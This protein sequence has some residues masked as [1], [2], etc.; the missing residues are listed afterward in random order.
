MRLIHCA[1]PCAELVDAEA[2]AQLSRTPTHETVVLVPRE[3]L[4][5]YARSAQV[6]SDS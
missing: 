3:L 1:G 5:E 2:R 6:E 4:M